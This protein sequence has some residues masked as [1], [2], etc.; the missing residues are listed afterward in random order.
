M[1]FKIKRMVEK[2]GTYLAAGLAMAML[3]C[4][5]PNKEVLVSEAG[6]TFY[7]NRDVAEHMWA[8]AAQEAVGGAR[9]RETIKDFFVEK[10]PKQLEKALAKAD[11]NHDRTITA[12]ELRKS[13]FEYI[14]QDEETE[15]NESVNVNDRDYKFSRA[16]GD[17]LFIKL[18]RDSFGRKAVKEL[19]DPELTTGAVLFRMARKADT[20]RDYDVDGNEW[21]AF[22]KAM[23]EEY[24]IRPERKTSIMF[25][26]SL[27]DV[28]YDKE[29]KDGYMADAYTGEGLSEL[30]LVKQYGRL[31]KEPREPN[32]K[33]LMGI[34]QEANKDG[35]QIISRREYLGVKSRF[36]KK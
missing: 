31:P 5:N 35:D 1:D 33:I 29:T 27:K 11:K 10:C 19:S 4:T 7:A 2:A 23:D 24:K 3:G 6:E 36:F 8:L 18:F 20:N 30:A 32:T 34:C 17:H 14:N 9:P 12:D 15:P 26:P 16:V 28:V 22:R 25:M 21:D 13:G